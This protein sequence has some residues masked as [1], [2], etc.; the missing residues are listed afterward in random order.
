MGKGT[1]FSGQPVLS[2]LIKLMDR[3]K[4]NT[5]GAT[6]KPCGVCQLRHIIYKP[7]NHIRQFCNLFHHYTFSKLFY[8]LS[9]SSSYAFINSLRKLSTI[10]SFP[11]SLSN[12]ASNM[13]IVFPRP[14]TKDLFKRRYGCTMVLI[15]I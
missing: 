5:L 7:L 6:D 3:Q 9:S 2:Q 11:S 4:I 14:T 8:K 15:F 10:S 1:N 13:S 12:T